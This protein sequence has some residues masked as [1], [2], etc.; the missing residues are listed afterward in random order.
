MAMT[1]AAVYCSSIERLSAAWLHV[2]RSGELHGNDESEEICW[3]A[4]SQTMNPALPS[5]IVTAA[6]ERD[7]QR[8]TSRVQLCLARR[9][10]E[11]CA[12]RVDRGGR[13][14]RGGSGA[15]GGWRLIL[16]ISTPHR[17]RKKIPLQRAFHILIMI[18]LSSMHSSQPNLLL[19]RKTS[20]FREVSWLLKSYGVTSCVGDKYA[21]GYNIEDF[22]RC[23]LE[24][25][26]CD[27]DTS[28]YDYIESL[29]VFTGPRLRADRQSAPCQPVRRA[30]TTHMDRRA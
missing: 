7:P 3:L 5:K 8:R 27:K 6:M 13:G 2:R 24:Y 19:T 29:H 1:P 18:R 17:E 9:H 21:A 25:T 4:T 16:G 10:R 12:T 26:Y 23:G 20:T 15:V 14:W 30:R 11:L 28:K 22:A